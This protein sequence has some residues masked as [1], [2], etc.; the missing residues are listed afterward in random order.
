MKCFVICKVV[1]TITLCEYYVINMDEEHHV[2][3][4]PGYGFNQFPSSTA[5]IK[6]I[7][8]YKLKKHEVPSKLFPSQMNNE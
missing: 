4:F 7:F 2:Y 1:D 3:K 6:K 8:I 5:N